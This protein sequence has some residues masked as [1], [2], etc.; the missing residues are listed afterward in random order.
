MISKQEKKQIPCRW[1]KKLKKI[2]DCEENG[3]IFGSM[4]LS[5]MLNQKMLQ[6]WNQLHNKLQFPKP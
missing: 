1:K 3:V 2:F 5:S 4:L 6:L